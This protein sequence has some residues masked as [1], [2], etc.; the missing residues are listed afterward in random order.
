MGLMK[1]APSLSAPSKSGSSVQPRMMPSTPLACSIVMA[2]R[3]G[4]TGIG[5][6]GALHDL[7]DGGIEEGLLGGLDGLEGEAFVEHGLEVDRRQAHAEYAAAVPAAEAHL[8]EREVDHAEDV[9]AGSLGRSC[10]ANMWG[11]LE[12]MTM[13][14]QTVPSLRAASMRPGM[15]LR[16]LLQRAVGVVEDGRVAQVENDHGRVAGVALVGDQGLRGAMDAIF[17]VGG[18]LRTEAAEDADGLHVRSR[19]V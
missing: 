2:S 5:S 3:R 19:L 14:S 10:S 11:P 9:A 15:G 12:A 1:P 17:E 16:R 4:A 6:G 18:G 7:D 8:G 13:K